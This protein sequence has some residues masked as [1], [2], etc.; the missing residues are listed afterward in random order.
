MTMLVS[1]EQAKSHLR[2]DDDADDLDIERKIMEASAAVV[3]YLGSSAELLLGLNTGGEPA[4]DSNGPLIPWQVRAATLNM[5]AALY[6]NRGE[7]G[8]EAAQYKDGYL[9]PVVVALLYPLR[10]PALG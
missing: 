3:T 1:L 6:E 5:L 2:V 7:D 4:S 10:T 8:G 9:P